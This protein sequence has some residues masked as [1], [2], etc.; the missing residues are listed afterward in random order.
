MPNFHGTDITKAGDYKI[1]KMILRSGI[2]DDFVDIRALYTNFEVFEDLFSP[3]MTAK[4]YMVDSLNLSERLPIRGQETLE[5][6]FSTDFPGARSIKKTFKV[7]KIDNQIIDENGRGQ[8]YTLHLMSEGGYFNY[9]ER[10][11][12]S[13][14][15]KVS[16][17]VFQVFKKHFP[18]YLWK[19]YLSVQ[20]TSDNFS[21][22]LPQNFTPFKAITWLSRKAISGIDSDY[23]PYF[24]YETSDG[25]RF[26]SLNQIIENGE[27]TKDRYYFIKS[28]VNRNFERNESS[29]LEV[30]GTASL[31]GIYNKIQSLQ[32]SLRFDMVENI[33]SGV[34][35]SHMIVQDLVRKEK[36]EYTFRE[37]DV[38]KTMKKLGKKPHYIKAKQ[39]ETNEFFE[40]SSSSYFFL[41]FSPYTVYNE[42]NNIVDNSR[43][44]EY[45]LKR[46]YM[47]NTMMTQKISAEIYGDSTKRVGQIMEIFIP[48]ISA[49][50]HLL[51][52]PNDKVLSGDYMIT[53]IC[54]RFGKH[55]V[56]KL[57]LSRNCMGV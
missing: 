52:E 43:I 10:C 50:G 1:H 25:Y 12:Y 6:E 35:A 49:D 37:S 42:K 47:V 16:D 40:K 46:K 56:C 23:S 3:Y 39:K 24:F 5:L 57:E 33:G 55:Y 51:D 7:Y 15:G 54:H 31:P 22:V 34:L 32:E 26:E 45:F 30:K 14:K 36:R 29:G 28:N 19:E 11:G 20:K 4:I 9:T 53:S 44:E 41:P 18:E 27:K 13:V 48:K 21:Y 38:F 2:S 8:Q 17:M